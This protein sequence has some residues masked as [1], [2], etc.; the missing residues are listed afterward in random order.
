MYLRV[1]IVLEGAN[2]SRCNFKCCEPIG[3]LRMS[4]EEDS[5][6]G[7]HGKDMG[8]RSCANWSTGLFF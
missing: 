5:L 1:S 3:C 6:Q 8:R 7:A 4:Q 2:P